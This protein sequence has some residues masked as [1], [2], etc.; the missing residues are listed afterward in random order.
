MISSIG[1]KPGQR[2][3]IDKDSFGKLRELIYGRTGIHFTDT[4]MYLLETRLARRLQDLKLANFSD[5]C[6]YLIY[7][8]NKD[9]EVKNLINTIVTN[10]T[11][12]FRDRT[13]LEAFRVGVLPR[14]VDEKKAGGPAGK[15]IRLWSSASSTGEEPY[16]LAMMLVEEGLAA[17]GWRIEVVGSDISDNVLVSAKAGHYKGYSIRNTPPEYL[18]RYFSHVGSEVYAV[19]PDIKRLVSFKKINLIDPDQTKGVRGMDVVF[20]RNVLIYFD[21]AA[22]KKVIGH[23]YDNLNPGGYLV[24]GFSESLHNITRLFKP[25]SMERSIVYQKK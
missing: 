13:Q 12:F 9:I 11:S 6:N 10:E 24:I 15:V 22:K 19:K 16:T 3:K 20:C 4:K 7:D 8:K 1:Y 14:I 17:S 21:D 25:E 23:I 2:P 5:Y 18:Q